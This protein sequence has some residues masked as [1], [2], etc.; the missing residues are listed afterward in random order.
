MEQARYDVLGL[1]NINPADHG[2]IIRDMTDEP[3][4]IQIKI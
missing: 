2:W 1:L 3:A 4:L